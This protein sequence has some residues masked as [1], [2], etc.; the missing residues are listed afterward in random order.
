[1]MTRSLLSTAIRRGVPKISHVRASVSSASPPTTI[2]AA[3]TRAI[4]NNNNSSNNSQ[5]SPQLKSLVD[6]VHSKGIKSFSGLRI[7]SG[8]LEVVFEDLTGTFSIADRT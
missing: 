2:T 6:H 7:V 5:H 8:A 1:M 4:D 3:T